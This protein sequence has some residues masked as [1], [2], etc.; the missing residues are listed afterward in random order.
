MIDSCLITR[1]YLQVNL[2]FNITKHKWCT[3]TVTLREG[4]GK[5]TIKSPSVKTCVNDILYFTRIIHR[6]QLLYPFKVLDRVNLFDIDIVYDGIGFTA[7]SIATRLAISKALCSFISSKEVEYL[8]LAGLLTE[9]AR[10][11][12][13]KQPGKRNAR[14]KYKFRKR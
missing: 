1:Y 12:E 14:R 11:K 7:Q 3:A 10:R 5:V 4:T 9:D 13:R 2:L 6:D 8:R